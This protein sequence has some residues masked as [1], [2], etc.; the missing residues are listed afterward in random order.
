MSPRRQRLQVCILSMDYHV[1]SFVVAL[2]SFVLFLYFV[3]YISNLPH[4]LASMNHLNI[5][6][7]NLLGNYILSMRIS[8]YI[9]RLLV[10]VNCKKSFIGHTPLPLRL[11]LRNYCIWIVFLFH[12]QVH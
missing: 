8:D 9:K 12:L 11:H 1:L 7:G 10:Q 3:I 2:F 5:M 4:M 6:H